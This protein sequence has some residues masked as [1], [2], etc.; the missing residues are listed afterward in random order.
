MNGPS[1]L[2]EVWVSECGKPACIKEDLSSHV[3]GKD[4]GWISHSSLWREHVEENSLPIFDV[5]LI[6]IVII[7]FDL[8]RLNQVSG[9]PVQVFFGREMCHQ[10]GVP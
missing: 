6:T 5:I 4:L 9:Q 1:C 7:G 2:F 3:V 8:P 10:V